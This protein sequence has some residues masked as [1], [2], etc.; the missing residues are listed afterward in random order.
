MA[1]P[2]ISPTISPT[3]SYVNLFARDPG[4]LAAFYASVFGFPEVVPDR[5]PIFHCLQAGAVRLGFHAGKAYDLLDL[6]DRRPNDRGVTCYVT[7]EV[8]SVAE[9]DALCARAVGHGA[10]L[11]KPSYL[12][13]YGS[14][15]CVLT[16][17]ESNVF[18]I[19]HVL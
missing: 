6:A 12:T 15:Q 16:D 8:A 3:I 19:N 2:A 9:L 10:L 13:Y 7:V 5:S 4:S 18:R 14:Q 11:V 17:P 1:T